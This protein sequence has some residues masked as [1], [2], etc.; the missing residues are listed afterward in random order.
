[1]IRQLEQS[2]GEMTADLASA[3]REKNDLAAQYHKF[4][5]DRGRF[6]TRL[7]ETSSQNTSFSADPSVNFSQIIKGLKISQLYLM[8]K[9]TVLFFV[10]YFF[11]RTG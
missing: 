3:K 8:W 5:A 9:P 6:R 10:W 11:N 2:L 1:L 4:A 7:P